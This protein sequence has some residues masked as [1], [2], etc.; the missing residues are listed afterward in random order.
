[1]ISNVELRT[2]EDLKMFLETQNPGVVILKF[3]AS[4][5]KPCQAIGPF[6]LSRIARLSNDLIT[7]VQ[8]DI[9]DSINLYGF[10][11]TK[12]LIQGVPTLF[13][14]YKNNKSCIPDDMLSLI[15]I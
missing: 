4:W 6:I 13:A 2:K 11:K 1:M 9:D 7:V 10:L 12:R 14:Y 5:C 3:G 8:I 15:H